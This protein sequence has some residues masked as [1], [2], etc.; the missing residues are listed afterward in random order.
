M[1]AAQRSGGAVKTRPTSPTRHFGHE[2]EVWRGGGSGAGYVA[3]CWMAHE[4]SMHAAA[5]RSQLFMLAVDVC[6][7]AKIARARLL[8]TDVRTG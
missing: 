3:I 6:Y 1:K 8:A 7:P 4:D 5:S 2:L